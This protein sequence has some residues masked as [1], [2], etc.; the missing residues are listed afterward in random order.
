MAFRKKKVRAR[1]RRGG[2]K[3]RKGRSWKSRYSRGGIRM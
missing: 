3:K 1:K 2:F